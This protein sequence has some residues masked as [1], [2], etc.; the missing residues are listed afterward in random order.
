MAQS[1]TSL[2]HKGMLIA[3][4]VMAG[5][6]VDVLEQPALAA[7]AQEE[8]RSSLGGKGY[9]CPIPATVAPKFA[10]QGK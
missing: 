9:V 7:A 10:S 4:K 2:A 3:A 6:A 5:A 1:A 8:L